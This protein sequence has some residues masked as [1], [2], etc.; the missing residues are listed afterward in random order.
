MLETLPL[1][2]VKLE[3]WLGSVKLE[4]LLLETMLETCFFESSDIYNFES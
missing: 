4:T 2:N 3:T 1:D